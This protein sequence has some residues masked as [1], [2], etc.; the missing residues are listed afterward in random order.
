M[1][2][3]LEVRET[4]IQ[5]LLQPT[6]TALQAAGEATKTRALTTTI[7]TPGAIRIQV[8]MTIIIITTLGAIRT[9]A[10]MIITTALGETTTRVRTIITTTTALG[11]IKT[12]ALMTTIVLGAIKILIRIITTTP[13][14]ARTRIRITMAGGEIRI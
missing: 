12:R 1:I 3:T 5:L 8:P 6:I 4:Q 9:P 14:A 10:Q 2:T 7:T 11:G 13:G